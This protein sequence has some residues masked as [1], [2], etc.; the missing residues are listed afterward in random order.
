M[1]RSPGAHR[2]PR[3]HALKD[4]G[5]F[6]GQRPPAIEGL[7]ASTLQL[8]QGTWTTVLDCLSD[9][10]AHVPHEE[11]VSRVERGRVVDDH[12]RAVALTTAFSA[13]ARIHYYREVQAEAPIPFDERVLHADDHLLVADK[14][15]F[16]PVTPV[17]QYVRET[18]L[19][20]LIRRTGNPD[21]VPL[22]R[23][24]RGTAGLVL[25]SVNPRSRAAYQSLFREHLI[26]KRYIAL[27]GALPALEFPLVRS[28]RI[29]R[30]QPF[31]VSAEV[32]GTPNA[33]TRIEVEECTG[34]VW[35]YA[36][37]PLTGKKHQ[38]RLHLCGLGAAIVN[39][40]LYPQVALQPAADFSRPLKLLAEQ[41]EFPDPVTGEVRRFATRFEL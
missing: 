8:P 3:S 27:A 21:I 20:R 5:N 32:P 38:L 40:E 26:K 22:H 13:G 18:L 34:S 41:L 30:G 29:V 15:H 7:A 35:R 9:H 36:L 19:A 1:T 37:Y 12:G 24:D 4:R 25:F 39:D 2:G 11:W 23:I 10:F 16:L 6:R 17:G 28:T 33:E 31:I 14:P